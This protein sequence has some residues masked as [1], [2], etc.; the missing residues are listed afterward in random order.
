[1]RLLM[2]AAVVVAAVVVTAVAHLAGLSIPVATLEGSY[3]WWRQMQVC[4]LH[5]R[6]CAGR[7]QW[8]QWRRHLV[9]LLFG[10]GAQLSAI[11]GGSLSGTL[12]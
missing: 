9:Q 4:V 6:W 8:L 10:L 7:L 3:P 5:T 12:G 2:A 11:R 1:M